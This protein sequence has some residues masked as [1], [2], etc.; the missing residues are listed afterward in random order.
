MAPLRPTRRGIEILSS[1]LRHTDPTTTRNLL[2]NLSVQAP[3]I[4]TALRPH[5]LSFDD[6]AFA[7][8]RGVQRMLKMV[9]PHDLALALKGATPAVVE[10]IAANLSRHAL[11]QIRDDIASLGPRRAS[12][13]AAAQDTLVK[14]MRGL[15][16][17]QQMYLERPG[18]PDRTLS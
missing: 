4:A 16:D 7:D 11:E 1:I 3:E 10:R 2:A 12:E 14:L 15:I 18:T 8:H 13:I 5:L 6:L 9:D 17:A